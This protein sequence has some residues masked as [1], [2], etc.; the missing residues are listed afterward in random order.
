MKYTLIKELSN[1]NVRETPFINIDLVL[2]AFKKEIVK[3]K[4]EEKISVIKT[5][6]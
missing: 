4:D 3:L 5:K 6:K 1:G 2:K